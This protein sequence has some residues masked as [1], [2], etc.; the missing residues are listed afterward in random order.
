MHGIGKLAVFSSLKNF[1]A[2][3]ALCVPCRKTHI[4]NKLNLTV[5]IRHF[6]K[7]KPAGFNLICL[8]QSCRTHEKDWTEQFL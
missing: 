7:L 3:N 2:T 5:N 6:I 1:L 8:P 4:K